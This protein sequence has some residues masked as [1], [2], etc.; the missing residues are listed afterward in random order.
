MDG[1]KCRGSRH[2]RLGCIQI[3]VAPKKQSPGKH[4]A[5]WERQ[6][7][8]RCLPPPRGSPGAAGDGDPTLRQRLPARNEGREERKRRR[9]MGSDGNIS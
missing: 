8:V 3:R 9:Q 4:P 2:L 6:R 5:M 1:G 7:E